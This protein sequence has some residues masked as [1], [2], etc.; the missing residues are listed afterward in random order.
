MRELLK[1][2]CKSHYDSGIINRCVMFNGVVYHDITLA[3]EYANDGH[4]SHGLTSLTTLED[5]F[6]GV[7]EL[8]GD[9]CNLLYFSDPVHQEIEV[10]YKE[11]GW[12]VD[13]KEIQGIKYKNVFPLP[14][15]LFEW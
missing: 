7:S 14:E 4:F 1:D 3:K 2:W 5:W 9:S 15:E 10:V 6:G 12:Y 13:I 8:V 11:N